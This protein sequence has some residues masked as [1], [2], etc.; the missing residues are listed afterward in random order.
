MIAAELSTATKRFAAV[1]ALDRVSLAIGEGDVL[2]LLGANG[3][4]KTTAIAL[5]LGLRVPDEGSARLFGLAP[6]RA[7]ARRSVGAAPQEAAFPPT[8]RVHEVLELVR[9]AKD[10]EEVPPD[11]DGPHP[12]PARERGPAPRGGDE[13]GAARSQAGEHRQR[14]RCARVRLRRFEHERQRDRKG[15]AGRG[16]DPERVRRHAPPPSSSA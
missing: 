3:A 2:A 4:G 9:R 8:L 16:P 5:L 10:E 7:G 6:R 14:T 1:T 15:S 12:P 13:K 11:A